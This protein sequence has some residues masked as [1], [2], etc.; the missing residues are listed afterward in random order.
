MEF[1]NLSKVSKH[2]G[3]LVAVNQVTFDVQEG[4]IHALIGP[5]GAG[6]TTIFNLIT[7][8]FPISEGE[9]RFLRNPI[10]HLKVHQIAHLG[11]LRTFQ[12]L[13]IF[14]E[15]TV[16]QNVMAGRYVRTKTEL[17]G[18]IL[19][20]RSAQNEMKETREK[21]EGIL[22]NIGLHDVRNELAKNLPYGRQRLLEIARILAAEGKLLLLDE[23][24]AG[25]N[26]SETQEL[27]KRLRQI[28]QTGLTILLVE[29][30]MRM[31]MG[32]S[33]Q[34][35]VIN[36]GVKIADGSPEEIQRNPLVVEAY[37]GKG[38]VKSA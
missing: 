16:L 13:K 29:H 22:Q 38:R 24:A 37:L 23:P 18:A 15:M 12:N 5:N 19:R 27:N 36:Y 6:K 30:D 2:F 4:H 31:V 20:L 3:G 25:L 1:L 17:F 28:V 33:D 26:P 35:T 32:V 7:G 21:A 8:V 10:H 11:I 9:I 34:I 14:N